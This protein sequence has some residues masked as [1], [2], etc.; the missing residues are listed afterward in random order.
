MTNAATPTNLTI[1]PRDFKLSRDVPADGSPVRWWNANDPVKTAFLNALSITFPK[2][3]AMF[4][5][6][7]RH[8]REQADPTLQQQIAQF[9]KQ[10]AMHTREHRVFNEMIEAAGYD[11]SAMLE[12]TE[13]RVQRIRSRG[14]YAQL[15][16]TVALE[17]FTAIM[18][19]EI[20]RNPQFLN[21][22]PPHI[23]ELWRYHA[24]EEIEHKGVAFDT[25]MAATRD[26]S[27]FKRWRVRCKAMAIISVLFWQSN[28]KHTLNFLRQDGIKGPISWLKLL[29]HH[30][31]SP[32]IMRKIAK[33]YFKFFSPRFHPWNTD[34]RNL[35]SDT[36][37]ALDEPRADS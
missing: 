28:T 1:T 11:T 24:I 4:I 10:E 9:I 14:P 21:D 18:S 36:G 30:Y 7:V 20:L 16:V 13:R 34:D 26:W 3:E 32:G 27:A 31:L 8:F 37:Q 25:Y 33:E 17:H 22:M 29:K 12:F 6:A 15:A 23:A 35:I 19:H 2:G 5:E